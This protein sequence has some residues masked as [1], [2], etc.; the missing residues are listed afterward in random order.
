MQ[1]QKKIITGMYLVTED[2]GGGVTLWIYGNGEVAWDNL[3]YVHSG[4]EY[5]EGALRRD[6]S[7]LLANNYD[8]SDWEGNDIDGW[9]EEKYDDYVH[10]EIGV[11]WIDVDGEI[12]YAKM[13]SA[14][15][16]IFG[17]NPETE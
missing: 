14:A 2:S 6:L 1:N 10:A 3:V 15:T 11:D 8:T 17:E 12:D 13:G 5:V 7:D 9:D 16:E 4:Y